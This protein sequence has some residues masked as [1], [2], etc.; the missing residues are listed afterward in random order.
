M[1]RINA[2]LVNWA[3]RKYKGLRTSLTRAMKW[4]SSLCRHKPDLFAHWTFGA[5]PNGLQIMGAVCAERCTY[6]SERIS[7]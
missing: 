2:K 3:T 1:F 5:K 7:G 4:V 6:G